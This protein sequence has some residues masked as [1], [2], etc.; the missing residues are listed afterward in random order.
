MVKDNS[1]RSSIEIYMDEIASIP[2][3]N[4]DDEIELAALISQ[5]SQEALEKLVTSNLRLVVK[6]AHDFKKFAPLED[7]VSAGN[8]GLIRAAEKFDPHKGSKF[9]S[10]AAWW[11]KQS[12]RRITTEDKLIV[13]P[14]ASVAKIHKIRKGVYKLTES[15]GREPTDEELAKHIDFTVTVVRRYRGKNLD[16]LPVGLSDSLGSDND[17]TV[18]DLVPDENQR[19]PLEI[20]ISEE[21]HDNINKALKVLSEKERIVIIHRFGLKNR[22]PKTLDTISKKI[23]RTRERVRQIQN[24]AL[25]KLRKELRLMDKK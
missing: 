25:Y 21:Y 1:G 7:V 16:T 8:Q 10:Y 2:L 9:S 15:L 5:G 6:I 18:E 17:G 4:K 14:I 3:L 22:L 23:G 11:I 12:I 20:M 24:D 19:L 13:I